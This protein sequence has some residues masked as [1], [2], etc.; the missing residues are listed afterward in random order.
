MARV[1][2]AVNV[3]PTVDPAPKQANNKDGDISESKEEPQPRTS[4]M[5][6]K[7][8]MPKVERVFFRKLKEPSY[9]HCMWAKEIQ[10]GFQVSAIVNVTG[11]G[12]GV[13]VE[14]DVAIDGEEKP[15]DL[16]TYEYD[17]V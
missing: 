12:S 4:T 8:P 17:D 9:W 1:K 2:K 7:K 3:Y 5:K 15:R 13:R 6:P 10:R 16:C 14:F 11:T